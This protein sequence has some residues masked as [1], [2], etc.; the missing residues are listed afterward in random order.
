MTETV[1][2]DVAH[3]GWVVARIDGK[4]TFCAGGL[5]G[6]RVEVEITERGKRFDRALVTRVLEAHPQRVAAPCP[7]ADRCGGCDWQH[8]SPALQLELKRR[9]VAEQLRHLA[10]IEWDK[11]VQPVEP[12]WGWRTRMRYLSVDGKLAMRGRRSNEPVLLP[13]EGC[14]IASVPAPLPAPRAR[15]VGV[16]QGARQVSILADNRVVSGPEHLAQHAAGRSFQVAAGGFWQVH[17]QAADTLVDAVLRALQPREGDDALDLYCGV[18]L[19]AGALVDA[20]ARVRGV[21]LDR[22]A[23]ALARGNVPQ[24]RFE[25]APMERMLDRLPGRA[26]IVVLDPPRKGAGREVVAAV[27]KRA[28]RAIAYVAC[29]PA[30]LGRDLGLFQASGYRVERVEAFDLFPQTHHIECVATLTPATSATLGGVSM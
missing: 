15:E 10:G 3:G 29:D 20:G 9:V 8:A 6:E 2:G 21:E 27:A 5:P 18:G 30:A 13:D 26:D 4:V 24:A 14:R 23:V 25:A 12:L 16:V 7:I 11:T 17:P 28:P 22:R 19:F 1:L